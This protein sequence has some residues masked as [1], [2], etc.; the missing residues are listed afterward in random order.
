MQSHGR[1]CFPGDL[2]LHTS[3]SSPF[4]EDQLQLWLPLL[5][6][7]SCFTF[8]LLTPNKYCTA[9]YTMLQM[10]WSQ[11]C[12][13]APPSTK[14]WS[15]VIINQSVALNSFPPSYCRAFIHRCIMMS[16]SSIK[17]LLWC[18]DHLSLVIHISPGKPSPGMHPLQLQKLPSF[19]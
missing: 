2:S 5:E 12:N 7:S 19:L 4:K 3:L 16:H 14:W 17:G 1:L 10:T 6:K 8:C 15:L 18:K 11:R 13:C 9:T